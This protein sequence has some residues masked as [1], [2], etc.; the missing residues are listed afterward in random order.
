MKAVSTLERPILHEVD[1]IQFTPLSL[2]T[3]SCTIRSKYLAS[4]E[5]SM[6]AKALLIQSCSDNPRPSK[7]H[8][9][10]TC[11]NKRFPFTRSFFLPILI[12]PFDFF[13]KNVMTI[14]KKPCIKKITTNKKEKVL[15]LKI[16]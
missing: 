2:I 11:K 1:L 16:I 3:F 13:S 9:E 5:S 10:T 15:W 4:C 8:A 12:T 7:S 6:T 14:L